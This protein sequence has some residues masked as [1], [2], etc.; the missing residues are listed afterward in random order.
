MCGS[1]ARSGKSACSIH[2]IYE[3]V[4]SQLVLADIQEKARYAAHDEARLLEQIVR[5]K[6]KEQRSRTASCEQ[7]LKVVSARINELEKLMQNLYEDKCVGVV[8]QT[9]FSVPARLPFSPVP[10]SDSSPHKGAALCTD[11]K[12]KPGNACYECFYPLCPYPLLRSYARF[13][14]TSAKEK[15]CNPQKRLQRSLYPVHL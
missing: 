10:V 14:Q 1:Y 8:P 2:T 9:V 12:R 6:S 3:N 7:E 15:R 5:M 4:L 11:R 13:C